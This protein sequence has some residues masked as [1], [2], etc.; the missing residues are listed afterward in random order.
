MKKLL[1][2][3]FCTAVLSASAFAHTA[4]TLVSSEKKTVK[5]AEMAQFEKTRTAGKVDGAN[6]AF[7]DKEIRLV[8]M[9]G[10][11]DD[12]LSYR[13]Q[14]VRNPNLVVPAGA[15]L[16]ILFVN[17]DS[18]MRHDVR[19]GH[20]AGDLTATPDVSETAGSTKLTGSGEVE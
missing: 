4:F 17:M 16:K 12:M 13:I 18:D 3:L 11:E 19:F 8:V 1:L 10:P 7:S 9:T 5:E 15:I 2:S 20:I 14:G 6:L